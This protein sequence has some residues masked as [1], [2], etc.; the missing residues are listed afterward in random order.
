MIQGTPFETKFDRGVDGLHHVSRGWFTRFLKRCNFKSGHRHVIEVDRSKWLTSDN[1]K[2]FYDV[3]EDV[4][5]KAKVATR[6][7]DGQ[8]KILKPGWII[9]FDETSVTMDQTNANNK[10]KTVLSGK[11][12]KGSSRG[13]KGGGACLFLRW[14]EHAGPSAPRF[15]RCTERQR[16]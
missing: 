11:K 13:T 3:F 15:H 9:S 1:M 2:V 5:L 8:L 16:P 14:L 12:D 10:R 7:T 6:D 4:L